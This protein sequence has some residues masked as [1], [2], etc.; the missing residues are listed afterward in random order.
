MVAIG[1]VVGAIL[2][3]INPI[4]TNVRQLPSELQKTRD[5]FSSWYYQDDAWSGRWINNP[6]GYVD[7]EDMKLSQERMVVDIQV[8]RGVIDGIVATPQIC[9]S[10]PSFD[11]LLLRGKVNSTRSSARVIVWD[12]FEGHKREVASLNLKR[13]EAVMT[14]VPKHGAV[15]LFPAR[16]LIALDANGITPEEPFCDGKQ[17]AIAKAVEEL[18]RKGQGA[19]HAD[20]VAPEQ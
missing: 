18:M 10:I 13:D 17:Q 3:N 12:V 2:L 6:E 15:K 1:G 11:F 7:A 5:Q 19:A 16:A 9:A 8:K 4:L 20:R 14:V